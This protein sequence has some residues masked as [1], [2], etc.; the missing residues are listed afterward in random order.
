MEMDHRKQY[1]HK[2]S[3]V[4]KIRD[5]RRQQDSEARREKREKVLSAKRFRFGS[6][7]EDSDE[8]TE[9]EVVA[10][11]KELMKS[12]EHRK[13]C[14]RCLRKAFAQGTVY[15]DAFLG[16]ENS[17]QCLVGIL[18][19]SDSDLQLEAVWCVTN[20]AAGMHDHAM[21]IIKNAAP[22]LITFLSSNSPELQGQSA[23]A[24]GNLAGD[25]LECREI[26]QAQG[27]I[28]PLVRLLKSSMESTVQS[29]AFAL[30]N[31]AKDSAKDISSMVEVGIIPE[32]VAHLKPDPHNTHKVLQEVGWILTYISASGDHTEALMSA[33]IM[34]VLVQQLIPLTTEEPH[35]AEAMTPLLRSLGNLCGGPD[36][37]S[38]KA[39]ENEALIPALGRCL[40][41]THRHIRLET[42]WVLSN[43][44]GAVQVSEAVM[45][46]DLLQSG[47]EQLSAA[48]DIKS[49][50]MYFLCNV[51]HHGAQFCEELVNLGAVPKVIPLLKSHDAELV[52]LAL[53]FC[54][55]ILRLT[56]EG[57]SIF[58]ASGG[59]TALEALEYHSNEKLR[60]ETCELLENY[61]YQEDKELENKDGED[62]KDEDNQD[63]EEKMEGDN[64]EEKAE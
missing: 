61:F 2:A 51:A 19:G 24:L 48:Y 62:K 20:I 43:M 54:E 11:T 44:A 58:E 49:E 9:A 35:D 45:G 32:I 26:L 5:R 14:L 1:K 63:Q 22:Y 10:S 7:G 41:S 27:V 57:K 31:I 37:I 40:K 60:Q 55:M 38:N 33:G 64:K 53:A 18:S 50:A 25:S 4:N 17:L 6:G 23:W 8:I 36:E 52:H 47:V 15:I 13:G 12:G 30:A 59:L 34:D 21:L 28:Q 3:D 29:A 16:V 46:G 56:K 42:L 39:C